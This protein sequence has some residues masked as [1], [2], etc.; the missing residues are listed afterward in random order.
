MLV[1]VVELVDRHGARMRAQVG[2]LGGRPQPR[3]HRRRVAR[4]A[5]LRDRPPP[6]HGHRQRADQRRQLVKLERP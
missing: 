3:A 6:R 5:Q 1:L 2:H 4:R